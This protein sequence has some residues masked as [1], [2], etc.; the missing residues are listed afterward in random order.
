MQF[1]IF[2]LFSSL[3]L[4]FLLFHFLGGTVGK[5]IR[6]LGAPVRNAI[7]CLILVITT[8]LC[9]LYLDRHATVPQGDIGRRSRMVGSKEEQR[10]SPSHFS[11]NPTTR[12]GGVSSSSRYHSSNNNN[13][14]YNRHNRDAQGGQWLKDIMSGIGA[15]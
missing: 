6:S 13:K 12:S 2:L 9:Y 4:S 7:M 3:V 8:A 15:R 11:S 1:V 10:S 5:Q 14:K